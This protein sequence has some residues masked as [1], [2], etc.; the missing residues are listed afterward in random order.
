MA[1]RPKPETKPRRR[2]QS[3]ANRSTTTRE[4]DLRNS[5]TGRT[6]SRPA[7]S[8]SKTPQSQ[9]QVQSAA[10]AGA[11]AGTNIAKQAGVAAGSRAIKRASNAQI[12]GRCIERTH[13]KQLR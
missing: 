12:V 7:R 6:P 1:D 4:L 2:V 11:R 5:P 8:A 9:K 13:P 10:T 3:P